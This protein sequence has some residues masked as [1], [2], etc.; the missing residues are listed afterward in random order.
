MVQS[1]T[2]SGS[3][4]LFNISWAYEALV[5]P[6]TVNTVPDATLAALTAWVNTTAY[7]VGD[8]VVPVA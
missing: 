5:G 6:Q 8:I 3:P 1:Q 4:S 7:V 2:P